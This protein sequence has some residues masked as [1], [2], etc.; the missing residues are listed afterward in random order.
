MNLLFP[1]RHLL[2]AVFQE[3]YLRHVLET[4]LAEL[5]FPDGR[6]PAA[7]EPIGQIIFAITSA[8]QE[9]SRY[10]PIPFHVRAIGV[11]RLARP[12]REVYGVGYRIIG[13]PHYAPTPRFA[14][15]V[16][17][18][19]EE[20]TEGHLRNITQPIFE[21]NAI[22]TTICNS[23]LHE[24]WSYGDR[25]ATV[26][27]YL[28]QKHRQT[29]PGGRLLIRDVVGP[30]GGK[31]EVYLWLNDQDGRNDNVFHAGA[32]RDELVAHLNGLS[33]YGRF[34]RFARD[35]LAWQRAEGRRGTESQLG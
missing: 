28:A 4:P 25:A 27:D 17:K 18:E 14:E 1:G 22:D 34:Q 8:N 30:A 15:N 20:Q 31:Q 2:N 29:R 11:D 7:Q 12:L 24:L 19:I 21:D 9:H 5:A 16:L 23:T 35:F 33:T 32:G 3:Q 10:N 6:T 26:H 13:I